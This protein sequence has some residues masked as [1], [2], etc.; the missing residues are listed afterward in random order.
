MARREHGRRVAVP[1]F[2][3]VLA[4]HA[5]DTRLKHMQPSIAHTT[6]CTH[7][8]VL[9]PLPLPASLLTVLPDPQL[10]LSFFLR[11]RYVPQQPHP[12]H[13]AGPVPAAAH[14]RTASLVLPQVNSPTLRGLTHL[15]SPPPRGSPTGCEPGSG[16]ELVVTN[17]SSFSH[18]GGARSGSTAS[19]LPLMLSEKRTGGQAVTVDLDRQQK[20]EEQVLYHIRTRVLSFQDIS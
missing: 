14:H 9:A 1:S 3:F 10:C 17:T 5:T 2:D 19:W 18:W 20:T 12:P 11:R 7:I 16:A 13:R 8:V 6:I 4:V 15:T